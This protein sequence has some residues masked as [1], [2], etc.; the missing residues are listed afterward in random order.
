MYKVFTE[1]PVKYFILRTLD[2]I[3]RRT[4]NTMMNSI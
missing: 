3:I 4:H 2:A 1:L